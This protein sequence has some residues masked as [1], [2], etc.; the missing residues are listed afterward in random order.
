MPI[1]FLLIFYNETEK[2]RFASSGTA[3]KKPHVVIPTLIESYDGGST[4]SGLN[5]GEY[6]ALSNGLKGPYAHIAK[7]NQNHLD[8]ALQLEK[9]QKHE[10]QLT[11]ASIAASLAAVNVATQPFVRM[12]ADLETKIGTVLKELELLRRSDENLT[13]KLKKQ[14]AKKAQPRRLG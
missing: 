14:K 5:T 4:S 10:S 7:T 3:K 11:A 13:T 9:Q 12:Q 1:D 2:N 6:A 8:E